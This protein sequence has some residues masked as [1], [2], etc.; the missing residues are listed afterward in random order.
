M[1]DTHEH[2][3]KLLPHPA[4]GARDT[5]NFYV[6][7]WHNSKKTKTRQKR[8]KH[9]KPARQKQ[10]SHKLLS[11]WRY[12]SSLRLIWTESRLHVQS[13]TQELKLATMRYISRSLGHLY[14]L[15]INMERRASFVCIPVQHEIN[16]QLNKPRGVV[17]II[18]TLLGFLGSLL[19]FRTSLSQSVQNH[20]S[21]ILVIQVSF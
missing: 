3:W 15:L 2:A 21:Y 10:R 13:S 19:W 8:Q 4:Q 16:R 18:T 12:H 14:S 1:S 9:R 6:V 11:W 5:A 20:L 7:F 17:Y